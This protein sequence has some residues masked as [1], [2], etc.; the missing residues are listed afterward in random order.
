VYEFLSQALSL[1]EE[2]I[3]DSKAQMAALISIIGSLQ[4]IHCLTEENFVGLVAK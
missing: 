1:F 2:E 4:K 3:P